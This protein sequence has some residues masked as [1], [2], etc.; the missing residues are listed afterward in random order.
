MKSCKKV[1]SRKPPFTKRYTWVFYHHKRTADRKSDLDAIAHD[2]VTAN[3][4]LR[5][6]LVPWK[7]ICE[8]HSPLLK[9]KREV[10]SQCLQQ[11]LVFAL[12]ILTQK[13]IRILPPIQ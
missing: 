8:D 13:E 10:G 1:V 9:A 11:K 7:K 4:F 3:V 6:V 5:I 12:T 2:L